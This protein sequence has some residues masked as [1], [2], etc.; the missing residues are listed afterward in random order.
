MYQPLKAN[1]HA[2]AVSASCVWGPVV[3]SAIAAVKEVDISEQKEKRD[4]YSGF[5]SNCHLARMFP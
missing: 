2:T 1:H 4:R 5:V 3:V